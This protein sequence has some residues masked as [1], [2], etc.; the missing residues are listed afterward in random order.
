MLFA[1][2][3]AVLLIAAGRDGQPMRI[4]D[5][6]SYT[7]PGIV[8]TSTQ[9]YVTSTSTTTYFPA[10]G[11]S[12]R[13]FCMPDRAAFVMTAD[14]SA[15]CCLGLA[16]GLTLGTQAGDSANFVTD[17]NGPDANGPCA[18][19]VAGSEWHSI[20]DVSSLRTNIGARV[21]LCTSPILPSNA[22]IGYNNVIPPCRV[23]ADCSYEGTAATA[24]CDT[25]ATQ[26]SWDQSCALAFCK[27]TTA[28]TRVSWRMEN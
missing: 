23:L 24:T 21:G 10:Q 1:S 22:P 28:N 15:T 8:R 6:A 5:P 26:A 25:N 3:G 19:L 20:V 12:N 17:A 4:L 18:A 7:R 16:Q 13:T 27:V 2:L 14:G 11:G 9:R